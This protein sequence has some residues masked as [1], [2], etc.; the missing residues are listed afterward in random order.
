MSRT[1]RRHPAEVDFSGRKDRR[2]MPGMGAPKV[3][4]DDRRLEQ[5]VKRMAPWELDA[6]LGEIDIDDE[7]PTESTDGP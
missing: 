6:L 2:T 7:D 4:D 3:R 5:F 1:R